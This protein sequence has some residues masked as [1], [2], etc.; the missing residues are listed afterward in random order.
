MHPT[1]PIRLAPVAAGLLMAGTL[2]AC[3][4]ND[5]RDRQPPA[6]LVL[7][8][9]RIVTLDDRR[10]EAD[11]LAARG[12]TIVAVGSAADVEPYVGPSTQVIDLG[13][14]FAMPGFIE[15]HG[16]F[17]G[18]GENKL[19]LDLL[20]TASWDEIVEIVARAAAMARPGQWIVGRGWHQDKWKAVPRPNVEGFPTHASL[21]KV[22][23]DN[24]V[25][26]THAS[27]HASFVNAK[28]MQ[29]SDITRGTPNPAGGE[30]LKDSNGDPTG[31]LRETASGLVRRGAGEPPLTREENE[32]RGRRVIELAEKEVIAKG[33]TSFQDAGAPFEFVDFVKRMVD[34]I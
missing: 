14:Q 4:L 15:G 10:P 11:A 21:D 13:G 17:A 33:S 31:L 24:P 34:E 23:P 5:R 26:L 27:G 28:A 3:R 18:I 20:Y 9:G 12:G 7:R 8:N 2:T 22:S 1:M 19:N 30:I 29:V 16:H 25:V 32:A 6:D